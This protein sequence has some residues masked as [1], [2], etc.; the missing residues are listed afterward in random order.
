MDQQIHSCL[1]CL[2]CTF[3]GQTPLLV[4]S[5][6]ACSRNTSCYF[7]PSSPSITIFILFTIMTILLFYMSIKPIYKQ[8]VVTILVSASFINLVI[9]SGG[10]G[11][12]SSYKS[13]FLYTS[14]GI[15]FIQF[16]AIVLWNLLKPC[17]NQFHRC[18]PQRKGYLKVAGNPVFSRS[19]NLES[20]LIEFF[21][22]VN[23]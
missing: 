5:V 16:C 13:A 6:T 17:Y 10:I 7:H 12:F 9:L 22:F 1:R 20:K 4:W 2:L 8:S 18:T 14:I 3:E 23:F 19:T 11:I 21:V 15:A